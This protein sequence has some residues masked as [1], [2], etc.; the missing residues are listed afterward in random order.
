VFALPV[1]IFLILATVEMGTH[2]YTRITVRHAVNEAARYAVTGQNLVDDQGNAVPRAQSIK[3]ILIDK[4]TALNITTANVTL[5]PADGGGPDDLVRIQ[6]DYV[7]NFGPALSPIFFPKNLAL[8]VT[9]VVKNEP[10][11]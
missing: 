7:Y 4:A 11:F 1:A 2:F 6:L 3:Q 5:D 8:Q 10:V 9:T